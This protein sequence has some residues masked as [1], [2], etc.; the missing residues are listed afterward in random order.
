MV[1]G[2]IASSK[3][4]LLPKSEDSDDFLQQKGVTVMEWLAPPNRKHVTKTQ[5]GGAQH[6]TILF[7]HLLGQ[8]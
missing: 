4:M 1:T 7:G 5:T 2:I 6:Q 3:S 8:Y